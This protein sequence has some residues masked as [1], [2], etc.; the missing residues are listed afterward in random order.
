MI[1][2]DQ[3]R[4]RVYHL[5]WPPGSCCQAFPGFFTLWTQ[6]EWERR[7]KPGS[8]LARLGTVSELK[9]KLSAF[10]HFC[11]RGEVHRSFLG[12]NKKIKWRKWWN[13]WFKSWNIEKNSCLGFVFMNWDISIRSVYATQAGK[14]CLNV[15]AALRLVHHITELKTRYPDNEYPLD[16]LIF[17]GDPKFRIFSEI[18]WIFYFRI[19][20]FTVKSTSTHILQD[21]QLNNLSKN[22]YHYF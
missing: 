16:I 3:I 12:R 17:P 1:Y 9:K 18:R 4:L 10:S 8:N 6:V 19:L 15:Y 22:I 13:L 14:F 21:G 5:S 11:H 20:G 7:R 2:S